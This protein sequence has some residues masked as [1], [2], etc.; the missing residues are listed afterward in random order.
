MSAR[1]CFPCYLMGHHDTIE[2]GKTAEARAIQGAM[3]YVAPNNDLWAS[4]VDE[5]ESLGLEVREE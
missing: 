4:H 3:A 2:E 5:H 1:R